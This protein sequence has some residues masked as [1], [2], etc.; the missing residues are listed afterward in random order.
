MFP[1]AVIWTNEIT[2]KCLCVASIFVAYAGADIPTDF[3][4][5]MKTVPTELLS[6]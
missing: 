5:C 6:C 2:P 4:R 1:L 3:L